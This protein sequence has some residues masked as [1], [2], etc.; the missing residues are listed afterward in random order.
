MKFQKGQVANPAGRPK[1]TR[2]KLCE[3]FI[4]DLHDLW[5]K[6]GKAILAQVAA[7]KP[8]AIVNAAT[9]LMPKDVNHFHKLDEVKNIVEAEL[10]RRIANYLGA[11]LPGIDGEA[12][13]L[14]APDGARTSH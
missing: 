10:D 13:A 4:H 3:D 7:D 14:P 11:P 6:Q 8:Q 12:R 5:E 2:N 9:K 1:G